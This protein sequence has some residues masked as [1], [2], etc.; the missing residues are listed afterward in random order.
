[1]ERGDKF[2]GDMSR[3]EVELDLSKFVEIMQDNYDLKERIREL[4]FSDAENPWAKWVHFAHTLDS[5]RVFPRLFFTM[6]IVLAAVTSVWFMGLTTPLVAQA[7][8]V[9][10]VMGVGAAWF[11]MYV[12]TGWNSGRMRT[13]KIKEK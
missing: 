5:Y 10:T 1:V 3:N 13:T 8:F 6:Y 12:S 11:G 9:S 2:R 7:G 4:E